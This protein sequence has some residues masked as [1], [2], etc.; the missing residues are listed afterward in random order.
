MVHPHPRAHMMVWFKLPE[1]R[2]FSEYAGRR[3]SKFSSS[4]R[5]IIVDPASFCA[6]NDWYVIFRL[7]TC[8]LFRKLWRALQYSTAYAFRHRS[9]LGHSMKSGA[10]ASHRKFTVKG[11]KII[12]SPHHMRQYNLR[13]TC[14][15]STKLYEWSRPKR[16]ELE[17]D[18]S[19]LHASGRPGLCNP[20]LHAA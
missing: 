1:P 18:F 6:A 7:K 3:D 11:F 2:L 19:A 13:G 14:P 4:P 16:I 9:S 10:H 17:S 12:F 20:I 8:L 5:L 15:R